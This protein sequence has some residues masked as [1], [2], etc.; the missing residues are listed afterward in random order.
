MK[1]T[2]FWPFFAIKELGNV[3][4]LGYQS[5]TVLSK[6]IADYNFNGEIKLS[7]TSKRE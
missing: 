4:D 7:T 1:Q 5:P 3:A 2:I 6:R